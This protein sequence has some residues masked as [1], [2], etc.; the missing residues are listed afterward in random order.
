V[1]KRIEVKEHKRTQVL[2]PYVL[3]AAIF[4]SAVSIR[5]FLQVVPMGRDYSAALTPSGGQARDID[6]QRIR[7]LIEQ[8]RLSDQEAE[9]YNK[10]E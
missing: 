2:V 7:T 10:V 5:R 3:A 6:I 1:H 9:F 4:V 8:K